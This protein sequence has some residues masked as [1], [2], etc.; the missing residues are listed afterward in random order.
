MIFFFQKPPGKSKLQPPSSPSK[1]SR[2]LP[3]K[4]AASAT[5]KSPRDEHV[6]SPGN[7]S[8]TTE[9]T[10][11]VKTIEQSVVSGRTATS[12]QGSSTNTSVEIMSQSKESK[13]AVKSITEAKANGYTVG[14]I[15]NYSSANNSR[16]SAKFGP[17]DNYANIYQ[18]ETDVV[19]EERTVER[20]KASDMNFH[21]YQNINSYKTERTMA[22]IDGGGSGHS[23][24]IR[25]D[26]SGNG[27]YVVYN[28]QN[29]AIHHVQGS[30]PKV[31]NLN[32][33]TTGN[34]QRR[35]RS[36][37]AEFIEVR[38]SSESLDKWKS[39][40]AK[41]ELSKSVKH[42]RSRSA[43][44][45]EKPDKKANKKADKES[46]ETKEKPKSTS[47]LLFMRNKLKPSQKKKDSSD[48]KE[49]KEKGSKL[50]KFKKSQ[51]E[52]VLKVEA[53][54]DRGQELLD[55]QLPRR[56]YDGHEL[57]GSRGGSRHSSIGRDDDVFSQ[58]CDV[59]LDGHQ[60]PRPLHQSV[61]N[62]GYSM[63]YDQITQPPG[64][65]PRSTMVS[66]SHDQLPQKPYIQQP[67]LS[68]FN[69]TNEPGTPSAQTPDQEM[70]GRRTR[71]VRPRAARSQTI[72]LDS[73]DIPYHNCFN[74]SAH[75]LALSGRNTVVTKEPVYVAAHGY[76]YHANRVNGYHSDTFSDDNSSV[77]SNPNYSDVY[78]NTNDPSGKNH[79]KSDQKH[80]ADI[81]MYN[82][83]PQQV[84]SNSN[85]A[86]VYQND[87]HSD[88]NGPKRAGYQTMGGPLEQIP[89]LNENGGTLKRQH[90]N[91]RGESFRLKL[92]LLGG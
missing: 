23:T 2:L 35:H 5:K 6:V 30:I 16:T 43:D 66:R 79:V 54:C 37:T 4:R 44:P 78:A 33:Q 56:D 65:P 51:G 72:T 28:V 87:H 39:Q 64:K 45:Y 20:S 55:M 49:D 14:V 69:M 76:G 62:A 27:D 29:G 11:P 71:P 47:R 82:G 26:S 59:H 89:E 40:G 8:N 70:Y 92:I 17:R 48:K 46:Q 31:Q 25:S 80:Y 21:I 36:R 75:E 12:Q 84:V 7:K 42:G 83:Q 85:Y 86:D 77:H 32:Y 24:R 68:L 88:Q 73:R 19:Q 34:V 63:S 3:G 10:E 61:A 53:K 50:L 91:E 60:V 38:S 74:E 81:Y 67:N 57:L 58:N 9:T 15:N 1:L 18:K 13:S 52:K 41:E 22:P 90:G